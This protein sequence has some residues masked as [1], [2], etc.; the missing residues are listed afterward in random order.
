MRLLTVSLAGGGV[1]TA[2]FVLSSW[3]SGLIHAVLLLAA[4]LCT[5]LTVGVMGAGL[6]DIL[7]GGPFRSKG[8]GPDGTRRVRLIRTLRSHARCELCHRLRQQLGAIWVCQ[9]C[10]S[11]MSEQA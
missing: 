11:P 9:Y 2:S 3:T 7:D 6:I 8:P 10:D 4:V 1:A 5:A